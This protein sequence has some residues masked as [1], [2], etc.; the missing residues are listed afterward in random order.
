[1]LMDG[2]FKILSNL[3]SKTPMNGK[4][5]WMNEKRSYRNA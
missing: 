3:F 1:M 5:S 2:C 4:R